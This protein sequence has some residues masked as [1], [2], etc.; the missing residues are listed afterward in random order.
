MTPKN[1]R[2]FTKVFLFIHSQSAVLGYPRI[3]PKREVKKALESY[4]G[5]KISVDELL[6]VAKEQRLLTYETLKAQGV[7]VIPT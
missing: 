3:G 2:L 5:G 6:K 1:A 4:W 7:D